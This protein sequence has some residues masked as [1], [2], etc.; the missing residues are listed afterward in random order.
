[1]S[2]AA[3][4]GT[5]SPLTMLDARGAELEHG[6][7]DALPGGGIVFTVSQRGRDPHLEIVSRAGA[8]SRLSVPALG[9][10][11]FVA[12]GHLVY[13]YLG[14]LQAVAFDTETSRMRGVPVTIAKGI[15]SDTGSGNLGRSGFAVSRSGTLV[16]LRASVEDARSR[17]VRVDRRGRY[18]PLPIAADVYQTPRMSPDGRYLAIVARPGVMTREIRIFDMRRP[19]HLVTTLQ[20]GDNQSPAWMPDSRRIT[21]GSNRD[22]L[23]KIYVAAI[24]RGEPRPLF[25]IDVAVPRNPAVWLRTPPLLALY[26][27]DPV[28]RRDV[29][30]YRVDKFVLPVAVT[31]ANE[32]SP[33]LAPDGTRLAYVSDSSGVDEIYVKPL[34]ERAEPTQLTDGGG[35]E[36]VWTKDGLFYRR[37]DQVMLVQWKGG[38]ALPPREVLDGVFERDPG[39]NLA[40]YDVEQGGGFFVMLKSALAPGEVRIVQHWDTELGRLVRVN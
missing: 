20:G 17:V 7:P 28:R 30:I 18:L 34:D 2:V 24:G 27:I 5:P 36:P 16:W 12:S 22:G 4:G 31:T 19:G 11:Q 8:R 32:R 15:Q 33:A 29:M 3:G 10:A 26:E 21:F 40:A 25:S 1:M 13:S 23:Q 35:T 37:D 39:A 6:W 9:Q 38:E 14:N